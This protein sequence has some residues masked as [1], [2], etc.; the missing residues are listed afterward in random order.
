MKLFVVFFILV[1]TCLFKTTSSIPPGCIVCTPLLTTPT[2]WEDLSEIIKVGCRRLGDAE[3]ACNGIIDNANLTDS[4]PNMYPHIVNF[5][6][7]LFIDLDKRIITTK[8]NGTRGDDLIMWTTYYHPKTIDLLTGVFWNQRIKLKYNRRTIRCRITLH[9]KRKIPILW[10]REKHLKSL[11]IAIN[12][13]I[14]DVFNTSS[15]IRIMADMDQLSEFPDIDSIDYLLEYSGFVDQIEY[16]NF[17]NRINIRNCALLR[18]GR[19][20]DSSSKIF[21]VNHL[22]SSDS[23]WLT[24]EHLINFEGQNALFQSATQIKNEDLIAF[25][26]NWLTGSNTKLQSLMVNGDVFRPDLGY[27]K[28]TILKNFEARPWNPDVRERR[29][30]YTGMK[31][32]S[33]TDIMDC[34]DGV[35]ILR[36]SDNLLATISIDNNKFCFFVWHDRFPTDNDPVIRPATGRSPPQFLLGS[37]VF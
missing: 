4:Y 5:R 8:E 28:D 1:V 11:P 18:S 10:C 34:T 21:S 35:D 36:E 3:D 2:T 29:F 30:K 17:F 6:K 33:I 14:C 32:L 13:A 16:Q 20:L 7:I 12:S 9:P 24:R 25:I 22:I 37:I 27:D 31:Y 15:E 26:E 23:E 19:F